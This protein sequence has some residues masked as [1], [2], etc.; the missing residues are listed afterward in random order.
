MASISDVSIKITIDDADYLA[1]LQKVEVKTKN[2]AN[3]I[4]T[5]MDHASQSMSK[6]GT[7][8]VSSANQAASAFDKLHNAI[9][10]LG[11]ASA[12]AQTG[13][14]ASTIKGLSDA[15]GLSIAQVQGWRQAITN[16]GGDA[17]NAGDALIDM[18]QKMN[19]ARTSG[20]EVLSTFNSLGVSLTDLQTKSTADITGTIVQ[21]LGEMKNAS[22][23][24]RKSSILM[25]EDAKRV[26]WKEASEN[27]GKYTDRAKS[28][29]SAIRSSAAATN[30]I[31]VAMDTLSNAITV[32]IEPIAV[33]IK[34]NEDLITKAI[35]TGVELG[36]LAITFLA[37][38]KALGVVRVI[39]EFTKAVQMAGVA[40]TYTG[41][42]PLARL[43]SALTLVNPDGITTKFAKMA[44]TLSSN[45]ATAASAVKN[46]FSSMISAIGSMK[47]DNIKTAFSKTMSEFPVITNTF[48]KKSLGSFEQA[49]SR[50]GKVIESIKIGSFVTA[51]TSLGGALAA[52]VSGVVLFATGL[53][54][55]LAVIGAVYIAFQVLNEII[56]AIFGVDVLG[57]VR[58]YGEELLKSVGIIDQTTK[59][60]EALAAATAEKKKKDEEADDAAKKF[61][62]TLYDFK[63]ALKDVNVQAQLNNEQTINDINLQ[64]SLIGVGEKRKA[65]A[66]AVNQTDKSRIATLD[67]LHAKLLEN[68]DAETGLVAPELVQ[69]YNAAVD[70]TVKLF[71]E[72]KQAIIE[73]TNAQVELTQ[74]QRIYEFGMTS[75]YASE[76]K[77]RDLKA[78]SASVFL[79]EIERRYQDI[80]KA[81]N[82]AAEAELEREAASRGVKK[83]DLPSNVTDAIR[84]AADV[85]IEAQKKATLEVYNQEKAFRQ[86]SFAADSVFNAQQRINGL[87]LETGN[88]G[89]PIIKKT[90]NEIKAAAN[91]SA[92]AQIKSEAATRN[93]TVDQLKVVDPGYVKSIEDAAKAMVDAE[94][95]AANAAYAAYNANQLR[96]FQN[97][98]YVDVHKKIRDVQND[99]KLSTMIE[100]EKIQAKIAYDA[101]ETANA[102]I[103]AEEARRGEKLSA[104]EVS[105]Y[106]EAAKQGTAELA[107][108]QEKAYDNTRSFS[109]GWKQAMNDY[110]TNATDGS[111]QAKSIFSKTFKGIEDIIVNFAKTGKFKWKEFVASLVEELM[112]AQIARLLSSMMGSTNVGGNSGGGGSILGSIGSLFGGGSSNNTNSNN[113]SGGGIGSFLGSLGSGLLKGVTGLGGILGSVASGIGGGVSSLFGGIGKLFG[114]LFADGGTL[115]AGKWG[116]VGE[117]GPEVI[118]GP[119][120]IAP[121]GKMNLGQPV[122]TTNVTYN[123]NAVDA[124]SFK[125]LLAQDPSYIY[126]L[127][128]QGARSIPKGR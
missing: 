29:E 3:T 1:K 74:S 68:M 81:A 86:V 57:A 69:E 12:I 121:I 97:K 9:A 110:V 43:A 5:D 98:E 118:S 4:K 117:A 28:S 109:T 44:S 120:N 116:I 67:Q 113:N 26:N 92:E 50:M 77:L 102:Q 83:Q 2:T 20:G 114:G 27:L 38:N 107:A 91:A 13:N 30:T 78:Q 15:T 94:K 10:G 128:M 96:L 33:F 70:K 66:E 104:A 25:G 105:A 22:D 46:N 101:Q 100:Y 41:A 48:M 23:A 126:A 85:N 45:V 64:T 18:T 8:A 87:V 106:Y 71:D 90:Y 119:A 14:Y 93:L 115:P 53:G 79:P 31:K 49:L 61:A 16:A 7:A 124:M 19:E 111:A 72:Q 95:E 39:G 80:T 127:S 122:N 52:G 11:I 62:K 56:K 59:E 123:I 88:T 32:A 37:L 99:I 51:L 36:K 65:I 55:I 84:K 34:N 82:D 60:T 112:R 6:V 54:E 108:E 125:T 35:Q 21:Q 75:L 47:W 73:A 24:S 89:L 40:A 103:A 58:D 42:G 76:A 17:D 63:Q